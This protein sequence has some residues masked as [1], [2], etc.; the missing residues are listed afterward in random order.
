MKGLAFLIVFHCL[1]DG[2][3]VKAIVIGTCLYELSV[4]AS[5]S[6]I[7]G[8]AAREFFDSFAFQPKAKP[9]ADASER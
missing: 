1:F 8:A 5:K 6:D 3:E 7:S 2:L 4:T 9:S